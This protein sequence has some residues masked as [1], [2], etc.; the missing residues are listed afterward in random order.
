VTTG[1]SRRPYFRLSGSGLEVEPNDWVPLHAV[2]ADVDL[3]A[4]W[5]IRATSPGSYSLVFNARIDEQ[6]RKSET[7]VVRFFPSD[8]V[9]LSGVRGWTDYLKIA[10]GPAAAFM[11]SLLTLPGIIAF[12]KDRKREHEEKKEEQFNF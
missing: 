9:T 12:F 4:V 5:S 10:S 1:Q 2:N 3:V 7:L 8:N 11:G 6:P